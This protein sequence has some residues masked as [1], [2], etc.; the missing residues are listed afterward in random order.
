[1]L[2]CNAIDLVEKLND[3]DVMKVTL[4]DGTTPYW[5]YN[6]GRSLEYV[7]K[8]VIVSTRNDMYHGN[9]VQVINTFVMPSKVNVVE[10]H[11]NIKL[12]CDGEDNF[13]NLSFNEIQDGETKPTCIFYC[14]AQAPKSSAQ[15]TWVEYIVR[16]KTLRTMKLRV[17]DSENPNAE[18]A[19]NYCMAAL[20][21]T[22]YGLQTKLILPANGEC[23]RN[24]EIDIAKNFVMDYFGSDAVAMSFMQDTDLISKMDTVVDYE[25]G[26]GIVRMAM[27]LSMCEQ[28]YNVTNSI[29]IK[30]IEHA[31]LASYAHNCTE[32]PFSPELRNV[33]LAMR[34]KWPNSSKLVAMIDP[35]SVEVR[36]NEYSIFTGIRNMVHAIL[37]EKKSYK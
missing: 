7:G 27:E 19:G 10:A 1:M 37:E 11:E 13:A 33:V 31:I 6:Y 30:L 34:C 12:F 36:P 35:G 17:F 5:F 26:Y 23:P 24:P 9:L 18:L 21:R 15:S 8:E 28:L 29:D 25:A 3:M 14:V 32:L 2:I 16:D 4:S 20:T 22:K